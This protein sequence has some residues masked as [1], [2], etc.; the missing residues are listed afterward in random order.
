M[1]KNYQMSKCQEISVACGR[2]TL[3]Q[4]LIEFTMDGYSIHDLK[5]DHYQ[6]LFLFTIKKDS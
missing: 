6:M 3:A 2:Y 1:N 4:K 5:W